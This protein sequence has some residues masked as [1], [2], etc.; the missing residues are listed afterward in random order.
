MYAE[1]IEASEQTPA[2]RAY[3]ALFGGQCWECVGYAP[4]G[5]MDTAYGNSE[6]DARERAR[7]AGLQ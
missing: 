2:E 5:H 6:S 7:V 4:D 1:R 3:I